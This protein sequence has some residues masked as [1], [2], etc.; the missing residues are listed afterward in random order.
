MRSYVDPKSVRRLTKLAVGRRPDTTFPSDA[1]WYPSCSD[2]FAEMGQEFSIIIADASRIQAIRAGVQLPG[3]V[4]HFTSGNS[5]AAMESI[6]AYRPKLVAIDGIFAQ[7]PAGMAFA[8]H[9]DAIGGISVRLV[10]R[11]DGKWTM[12]ARQPAAPSAAD[13]STIVVPQ[14]I[15]PA[16]A[17][18]TRRAPRFS[19]RSPLEA[20]VEGGRA[21]LVNLSIHGAQ[22]VSV[23]ALRPNQ[24]VKVALEDTDDLVNLTA[25]VAWSCFERAASSPDPFYR[26]GLEFTGAAQQTLEAYR[27]RYCSA[28]P[29][30]VSL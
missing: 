12:T 3:R 1:D 15:V 25:Q 14:T 30:P 28:Q 26:V 2:P 16:P 19:V 4:M 22:L 17:M 23:P 29:L 6:R 8:D 9:V 10:L 20:I 5:G 27:Q 11:H 13:A 21:T 24:R 18:N 7:T